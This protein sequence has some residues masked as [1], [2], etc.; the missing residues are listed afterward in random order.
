[1]P[2]IN[3]GNNEVGL[4]PGGGGNPAK[5]YTGRL[6]PEVHPSLLDR[7]HLTKKGT[8]FVLF[9]KRVPFSHT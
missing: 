2:S 3:L 7:P 8:P 4:Y 1:M 9:D 5:F 6:R